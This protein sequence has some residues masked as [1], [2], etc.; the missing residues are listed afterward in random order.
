MSTP[1]PPPRAP[2]NEP[3][4]RSWFTIVLTFL[5]LFVSAVILLA[6][7]T[8]FIGPVIVFGGLFFFLVI[9]F[10]YVVWGRWLNRVLAEEEREQGQ[11]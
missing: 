6:L 10:H 8:G 7:P 11:D 9:G 1:P 2:E 5:G 4:K 3:P